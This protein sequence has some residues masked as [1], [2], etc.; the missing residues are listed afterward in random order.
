MLNKKPYL[1]GYFLFALCSFLMIP[2]SSQGCAMSDTQAADVQP[3]DQIHQILLKPTDK[4][5]T[6]EQ[7]ELSTEYLGY[8]QN[9]LILP[10]S[11]AVP[12]EETEADE[13]A[14]E[15]K[16]SYVRPMSGGVHVLQVEPAIQREAAVAL[17]DTLSALDDVEYAEPDFPR[18][19]R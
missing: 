13:N 7:G 4:V 5:S 17:T 16:L 8:L 11:E 12:D 14:I 10:E 19:R 6:N 1:S 9:S 2:L 15:V 3:I 18:R